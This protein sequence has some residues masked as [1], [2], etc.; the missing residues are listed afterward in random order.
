MKKKN[1]TD[2]SRVPRIIIRD[3]PL[4]NLHHPINPIIKFH[5]KVSPHS[6]R[7]FQLQNLL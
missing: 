3:F 4:L 7:I 5:I 6:K 2:M 1:L